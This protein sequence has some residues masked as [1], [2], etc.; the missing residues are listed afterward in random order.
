MEKDC[1]Y[2]KGSFIKRAGD[3]MVAIYPG[4]KELVATLPEQTMTG[5]IIFEEIRMPCRYCPACGRKL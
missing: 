1:R 5:Q 3:M 2:C 4:K